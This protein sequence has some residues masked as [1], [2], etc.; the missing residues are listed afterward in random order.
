[1]TDFM[2]R[3]T[4]GQF[5]ALVPLPPIAGLIILVLRDRQRHVSSEKF[6]EKHEQGVSRWWLLVGL[7]V[8]AI[9]YTIP[10]DNHLIAE[11]VWSYGASRVNG[12]TLGWIPLEEVLFFP[13]QTILVGLWVL[14][15]APYLTADNPDRRAVA[16][17]NTVA[18]RSQID[19]T[20]TLA[21]PRTRTRQ[22]V[23]PMI[24]WIAV[25]ASSVAWLLGLGILLR[26][27]R[28]GTYL[29]WELVWA[30]PPLALQL[31]LGGDLLWQQ[32]RLVL[33]ALTPAVLYLCAADALAIHMGIWTIAPQQSLDVL[34]GGVL[35]LEELV[36]FLLTSALVTGGLIIGMAPEMR[37]RLNLGP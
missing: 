12:I 21:D 28:P 30:L 5:L 19:G 36:F 22:D 33:A 29:G 4:Y 14:W 2:T 17:E 20:A 37:K 11:S 1:M 18:K 9:V 26:G 35:P 31:G 15:L 8:L 10:W 13:L 27:W 25:A 32:R 16:G 34:L 23:A 24:R 3:L 6:I 7:V